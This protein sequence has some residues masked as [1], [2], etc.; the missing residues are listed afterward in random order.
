MQ[1]HNINFTQHPDRSGWFVGQIQADSSDLEKKAMEINDRREA[2]GYFVGA[3]GAEEREAIQELTLIHRENPIV[4][5][6]ADPAGFKFKFRKPLT[7]EF[8]EFLDATLSAG[9]DEQMLDENGEDLVRKTGIVH[10][11]WD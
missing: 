1:V 8:L 5:F 7:E 4:P 2:K 9:V 6:F 10:L 3:H 11:W